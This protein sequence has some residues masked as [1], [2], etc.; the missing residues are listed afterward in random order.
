MTST[1]N[2]K[3]DIWFDDVDEELLKQVQ[4]GKSQSR[5][6]SKSSQSSLDIARSVIMENALANNQLHNNILISETAQKK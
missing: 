1:I 3:N 4:E 6:I 5:S 2:T